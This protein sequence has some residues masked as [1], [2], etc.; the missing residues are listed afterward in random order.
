MRGANLNSDCCRRKDYIAMSRS[1]E[2]TSVHWA[3][4]KLKVANAASCY[5]AS[6]VNIIVLH[7]WLDE[8]LGPELKQRATIEYYCDANAVYS[9]VLTSLIQSFDKY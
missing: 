7:R 8:G 4:R 9:F 2:R 6:I 1:G 3:C 5:V